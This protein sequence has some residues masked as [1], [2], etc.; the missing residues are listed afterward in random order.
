[1]DKNGADGSL[2]LAGS[3]VSVNIGFPSAVR[4][5]REAASV[6]PVQESRRTPAS[7]RENVVMSEWAMNERFKP[8]FLL[9]KHGCFCR[10]IQGN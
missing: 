2:C 5:L 8:S 7:E 3:K 6:S 9:L 4:T 10:G 1:M